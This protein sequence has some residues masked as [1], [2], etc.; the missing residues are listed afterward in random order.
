MLTIATSATSI[1]ALTSSHAKP[2]F[3]RRA[4][5]VA[6]LA[7][8]LA[9][10]LGGLRRPALP[11][12]RL[13]P[14]D[15]PA[16]RGD[17]R[18]AAARPHLRHGLLAH[19]PRR[20]Q[21]LHGARHPLH[22]G[23]RNDRP[24]RRGRILR[25]GVQT[26]GSDFLFFSYTTLTTTGYGDLVPAGQVGPDDLR[27][28]DDARPGLPGHPGRRPGQPLAPGRGPAAP[29]RAPRR[30]RA[31]GQPGAAQPALSRRARRARSSAARPAGRRGRSA[32]TRSHRPRPCRRRPCRRRCACR[33][34]TTPPRW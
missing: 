5:L 15:R 19:D 18:G 23:L 30:R 21:R 32:S 20:D 10:R 16:R 27:P 24:D 14:R 28:R 2:R 7:I 17:G 8:L 1:V 25:R 11:Q 13:L 26:Q 29:P 6:A 31:G 34:A 3:V 22:L 9:A 4:A 33:R 12:R